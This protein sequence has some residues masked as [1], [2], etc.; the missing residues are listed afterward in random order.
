MRAVS[1]QAPWNAESN[2]TSF[3]VVNSNNEK[4]VSCYI[5]YR[6]PL[7]RRHERS[8]TNRC[9]ENTVG[10]VTNLLQQRIKLL[11]CIN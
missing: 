2:M 8:F 5:E 10:D 4:V 6:V 9:I 7:R 11:L 1:D 3:I